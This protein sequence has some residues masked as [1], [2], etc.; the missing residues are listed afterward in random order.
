[1]KKGFTLVELLAV[2]I[3]LGIIGLITIVSFDLV[4]KNS[5]ETLSEAQKGNVEEAA[6]VYY[7][8]EGMAIND[9]CVSVEEL[10][11]K[12]YIEGNVVKDPKTKESLTG[13]VRIT[14]KANQYSYKYQKNSCE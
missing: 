6:K 13:Y 8:K 10:I 14:Y 3:I 4:L 12:G 2:I 11:Q 1:M 7:L 5:K 9:T